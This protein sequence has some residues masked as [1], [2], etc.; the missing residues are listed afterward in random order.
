MVAV[1]QQVGEQHRLRNGE[2]EDCEKCK[3]S[4]AV[5]RLTEATSTGITYG[6]YCKDCLEDVIEK[7][8][9]TS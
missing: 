5:V 8:K 1:K 3:F 9:Q 6:F 4:S 7:Q 2:D